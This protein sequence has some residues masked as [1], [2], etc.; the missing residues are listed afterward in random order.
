MYVSNNKAG[1]DR[2][3]AMTDNQMAERVAMMN[4]KDNTGDA[5]SKE[6]ITLN[7]FRKGIL[8]MIK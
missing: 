7:T 1:R 8:K 2:C 3:R 6:N 5:G 4:D